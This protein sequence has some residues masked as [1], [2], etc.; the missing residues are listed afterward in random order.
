MLVLQY[1]ATVQKIAVL[2]E[3]P[4]LY[5]VPMCILSK[6]YQSVRLKGHMCVQDTV[7]DD[8]SIILTLLHANNKATGAPLT[9]M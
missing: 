8:T 4:S 7:P 6:S 2:P 3:V 5:A 9:D 1:Q